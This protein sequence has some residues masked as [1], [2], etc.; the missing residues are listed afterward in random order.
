MSEFSRRMFLT[1]GSMG[2]A[3]AGAAAAIPGLPALLDAAEGDAPAVDSAVATAGSDG[4]APSL[5]EPLVAHVT[6]MQTGEISL[7]LGEREVVYNDPAMA[8]RLLDAAVRK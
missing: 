1:R 3:I 5:A 6:D 8:A 4:V 7:F 2:I